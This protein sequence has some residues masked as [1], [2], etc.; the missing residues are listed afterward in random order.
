MDFYNLILPAV[1]PQ[2]DDKQA[3]RLIVNLLLDFALLKKK[4]N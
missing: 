1:S 4:D 2:I 3:D